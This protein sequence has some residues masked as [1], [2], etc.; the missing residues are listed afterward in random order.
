MNPD[1]ASRMDRVG[2][3]FDSTDIRDAIQ[4]VEDQYGR[5]TYGKE[6]FTAKRSCQ[7]E[8]SPVTTPVQERHSIL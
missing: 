8:P 7:L 5:S 4:E 3:L 1:L 6:K 2:V